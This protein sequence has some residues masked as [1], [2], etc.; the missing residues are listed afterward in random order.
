MPPP[1]LQ[2]HWLTRAWRA[3]DL[4][5]FGP[6][7]ESVT[8]T[9]GQEAE[10]L[11]ARYLQAKG[12]SVLERNWKW[13]RGEL[14]LVCLHGECVVVVE[15]KSSRADEAYHA[16]DRV[17]PTKRRQLCR[18]TEHFLKQRRWLGRPVRIDVVEVTFDKDGQ[19]T[20]RHLEA[21]V[22]EA[23]RR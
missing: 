8:R 19:P 17:G 5:F 11:A 20:I 10:D 18:L 16:A 13:H 7:A 4:W 3:F 9:R 2:E 22:T 1:R 23:R 12:Y 15:V 14:D 6:S 21:A